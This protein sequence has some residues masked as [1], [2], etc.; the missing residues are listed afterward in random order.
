MDA[1]QNQPIYFLSFEEDTDN[2][3]PNIFPTASSHGIDA[4]T[5]TVSCGPNHNRGGRR[6]HCGWSGSSALLLRGTYLHG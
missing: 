2:S 3:L 5:A 1:M 4:L 6:S